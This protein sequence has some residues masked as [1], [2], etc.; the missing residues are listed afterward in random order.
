MIAEPVIPEPMITET[1]IVEP[2]VSQQI[3]REKTG[4]SAR[5]TFLDFVRGLAALS[6]LLEHGGYRLSPDFR[7]FTHGIFSFGKFGVAAFFL[8]SGF[9]IPFSLERG[10][11]LQRFWISRLCRL[12]PL[13]WLSMAVVLS[14]YFLHVPYSV[15]AEFAA[16][17]VR[18]TLVNLTMLQGFAGIPNAEGL[19]YTIAQS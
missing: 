17:L 11:S 5:L 3:E 18:N 14:L 10:G 15:S 19:Y 12:Y 16:H 8:T 9:V 2:K 7:G 6:V 13:Y 1:K 4:A